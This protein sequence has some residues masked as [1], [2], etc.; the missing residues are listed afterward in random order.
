MYNHLVFFRVGVDFLSTPISTLFCR[1]DLL[2]LRHVTL[3]MFC[4]HLPLR[5]KCQERTLNYEFWQ[6]DNIR[7]SLSA[8]H[9]FEISIAFIVVLSMTW[10]IPCGESKIS[11]A[12]RFLTETGKVRQA[13][14]TPMQYH[15][16]YYFKYGSGHWTMFS[17]ANI[18]DYQL[19]SIA[20]I[21]RDRPSIS[22]MIPMGIY[23]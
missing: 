15:Y 14:W 2:E 11:I 23:L 21:V 7:P 17:R 12:V 6:L 18:H 20:K 8:I 3:P 5:Y 13:Y 16:R 9:N 1:S 19:L 22:S 4:L 10:R